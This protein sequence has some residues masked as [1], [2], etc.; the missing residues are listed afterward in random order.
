MRASQAVSRFVIVQAASAF[1]GPNGVSIEW[2]QIRQGVESAVAH[3]ARDIRVHRTSS[4][5]RP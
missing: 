2:R 1:L 5:S 4:S 3:W